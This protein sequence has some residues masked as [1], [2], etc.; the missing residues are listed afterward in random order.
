MAEAERSIALNVIARMKEYEQE[1][2]Q[3]FPDL[4][5]AGA[6][7]AAMKMQ[8]VFTRE[9]QKRVKDA[10]KAAQKQADF[11][12]SAMQAAT[13]AFSV[14]AIK[15]FAAATMGVGQQIAD[16][17]NEINDLGNM[18]GQSNEQLSAFGF[19]ARV[20][21]T[22]LQEL[23]PSLKQLPKRLLDFSRGTGEARVALD[24][25]GFSQQEVAEALDEGTDLT[26]E[27]IGRLQAV[28]SP[29]KRAAM[30]TQLFGE[31]G[32]RLMQVLGSSSLED[33]TEMAERYGV[34]VG[35]EAVRASAQWE[36]ASAML[37]G[38]LTKLTE[39]LF[40]S[41]G[42][43]ESFVKFGAY[44][45]G[46]L[47][48]LG[49]AAD[50][51]LTIWDGFVEKIGWGSQAIY[52]ALSGNFGMAGDALERFFR[53]SVEGLDKEIIEVFTASMAAAERFADDLDRIDAGGTAPTGPTAAPSTGASGATSGADPAAAAAA[54]QEKVA[55]ILAQATEDQR[56][57]SMK[58]RATWAQTYREIDEM[59]QAGAITVE[60]ANE[61][62]GAVSARVAREVGAIRAKEAQAEAARQAEALAGIQAGYDERASLALA[63]RDEIVAI[64]GELYDEIDAQVMAGL[65][66]EEQAA[67]E[68]VRIHARAEEQ[69]KE[70]TRQR[71]AEV[72][73]QVAHTTDMIAGYATGV[74]QGV[75][76]LQRQHLQN[77]IDQNQKATDKLLEARQELVARYEATENESAKAQLRIELAKNREKLASQRQVNRKSAREMKRLQKAQKKAAIAQIIIDGA[78][79]GIKAFAQL[80]PI[81]G[82][83]AAAAIGVTTGLSVAKVQAQPLAQFF[84]GGVRET[85]AGGESLAVVHRGEAV[86][87]SRGVRNLGGA[88][89]VEAINRGFGGVEA[90]RPSVKLD[91]R[92]IADAMAVRARRAGDFREAVTETQ[93]TGRKAIHG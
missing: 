75:M 25:L 74:V 41:A 52:H 93:R 92:E 1:M 59:V 47:A 10:R 4:T 85:G 66:T 29:S 83:I 6:R 21:G 15:G 86:L 77:N 90:R 53:S 36:A 35:P 28:E 50:V 57:E 18:I 71:I 49:E 27:M 40:E 55:A 33:W 91:G 3:K 5:E 54:A 45:A 19:A 65:V 68:R 60:R 43:T 73:D 48:G 9:E 62:R 24:A 23:T 7:K 37:Q 31:S 42:G 14:A 20:S 63:N 56:S 72:A 78:V 70:A 26:G 89:V 61:I 39:K 13:A 38:S 58:V 87:N 82:G 17:R 11:Y 30:A 76:D 51:V 34:K 8:A 2:M 80:G 79:A 22:S 88:E 84:R 64:W 81:A 46:A 16:M 32:V 44:A 69:I 12:S 67:A